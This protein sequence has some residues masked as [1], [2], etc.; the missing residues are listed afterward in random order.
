MSLNRVLIINTA[1]R[2]SKIWLIISLFFLSLPINAGS[3]DL[4]NK[5]YK[6]GDYPKAIEYYE[7]TLVSDIKDYGK[8]HSKVART[9]Y[10]LG[11]VYLA[12]GNYLKAI[13]YYKL[14]LLSDLKA[15]EKH[16]KIAK[17][18]WYIGFAYDSLGD[19]S[20]AIKYYD[21]ALNSGEEV[22]INPLKNHKP[23]GE[24]KLLGDYP[25]AIKHY[26]LAL[27]SDIEAYGEKHP[28]VAKTSF[29]LGLTYLDVGDY[30]EAIEYLE[31]ALAGLPADH[32]Y[33]KDL[34]YT[35]KAAKSMMQK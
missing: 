6:A 2:L 33:N 34:I 3:S 23:A 11:S 1:Y 24:Y 4:A 17:T 26:K 35:I 12:L 8:E 13:K 15:Y 29:Q 19:S 31:L 20:K 14:S 22:R 18:H 21:K 28:K 16:P 9:Q 25:K 5:A 30:P 7:Q 27:V 32:I 10:K